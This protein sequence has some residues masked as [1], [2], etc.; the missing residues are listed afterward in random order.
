MRVRFPKKKAVL[1]AFSPKAK[2]WHLLP[3]FQTM[4]PSEM[5]K[6]QCRFIRECLLSHD[7][8]GLFFPSLLLLP[9]IR[10]FLGMPFLVILV[11]PSLLLLPPSVFPGAALP[12]HSRSR[13]TTP[14][15]EIPSEMLRGNRLSGLRT[16]RQA[17]R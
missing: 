10:I 9:P 13:T 11:F 5:S 7:L 6:S 14:P 17:G 8:L 16:G 4:I 1:T 15:A 3:S 12:R 2:Q